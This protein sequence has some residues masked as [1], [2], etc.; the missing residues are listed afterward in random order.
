MKR[1]LLAVAF[2][3]LTS[4]AWAQKGTG[5]HVPTA[6]PVVHTITGS[7]LTIDIGD[8]TSVQ[9]YNSNVPGNG[10]IFPTNTTPGSSTADAGSFANIGGVLYAPDFSQHPQGTA[11]GGLGTYVPWTPVSFSA[12]TGSGTTSDPFTEVIVVSAGSTGV[13]LTETITYVNGASQYAVSMAF[14]NGGSAAATMNVFYGE[15]D[16]LANNDNAFMFGSTT[17]A[18]GQAVNTSCVLLQYKIFV[19]GTGASNFSANSFS[20]VWTEIGANALSNTVA[21]GCI[22]G[23]AALEWADLVLA[24]GGTAAVNTGIAFTGQAIPPATAVVPALSGVGVAA[25]V[26]FLAAMGFILSRKASLGA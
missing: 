25:L 8:E 5:P 11:T 1:A 18:G 16:Y 7:P 13:Q 22:D 12:V 26:I 6:A 21:S 24:A 4:P 23:G 14:A 15:D 17:Q 10:Q 2:L 9:V 19:F 3:A 20:T